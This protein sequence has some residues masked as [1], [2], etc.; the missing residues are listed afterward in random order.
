MS[1]VAIT[2]FLPSAFSSRTH[3]ATPGIMNTSS[4]P[5]TSASAAR[6]RI[7]APDSTA[8]AGNA[9]PEC[10]RSSF[11]SPRVFALGLNASTRTFWIRARTSRVISPSVFPPHIGPQ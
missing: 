5:T 8:I 10:A 11:T 4:M 6:S 3:V 7:S 1:S 2:I 9:A